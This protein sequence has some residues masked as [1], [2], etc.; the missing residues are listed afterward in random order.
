MPR[1]DRAP[2][3]EA[4]LVRPQVTTFAGWLHH[5]AERYGDAEALV[6]P[7]G[8]VV[9]FA[10]LEARVARV[11]GGL[12]ALGLGRG[13][14]VAVLLPTGILPVELFLAAAQ[15][16][17]ITVGI[18]TRYRTE[19]LGHLLSRARPRL[20]ISAV[21]FLGIDF[22]AVVAAALEG[23]PQ[24]PQVVWVDEARALRDYAGGVTEDRARP[25][26]LAIAFTTSGTT[27]RPRLAAHDHTTT[28]RHLEAA[29]RSMQV[30]PEATG[31]VVL[32]FCGTFGFV[33]VFMLLAGGGRAVVADH[34]DPARAAELIEEYGVTH[35]NGSDDM[36]LAVL[37]CARP[38]GLRSWG[39]GLAAE[40]TGR[41]LEAVSR[42]E[43][44]G[45]A[46]TGG[47]G[48]SETFA[49]LA[50]QSTSAPVAMRA[51]NGGMP[52]DPATEVR[53][54]DIVTGTVAAPGE[55]GELHIRGPSVLAGY[56]DGDRAT[57]ASITDDGWL[58]TGDLGR[59]EPDGGF[60]YLGRLGD[61]L[62]LSGFLTDP[63]EIEQHLMRH[64][65]VRGAQ[66][67]G[68]SP[69]GA[70]EVAV[71]FVVVGDDVDEAT[72]VGHCRSGLA[73][74]KVPRRVV[75]LDAFPVVDGANGVKIKKAELR[76][77]AVHLMAP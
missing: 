46:L 63:A 37:D 57:P 40:F 75:I 64:P 77:R 11:A 35:F 5:L 25:S 23:R 3:P 47:Y 54:V 41:A 72:L 16:G 67:V 59:V 68:A 56:L 13:D 21:S 58:A 61:A 48:S 62:R 42:A 15:L 45:A 17:A 28:L 6:D 1:S 73:N 36:L 10:A 30:D 26:D 20:L 49:I 2:T 12:Q 39:H 53:A 44:V 51:R 60:V 14:R 19:D 4:G 33:S 69:P 70:G 65:G 74:Y 43:G 52:V 55:D 34:F 18:N 29:A 31:L 9:S 27:G 66:V 7:G 76:E 50:R 71:A 22:P 8:E 24:P 32:P 38:G